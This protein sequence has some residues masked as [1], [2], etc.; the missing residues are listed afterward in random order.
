[1]PSQVRRNCMIYTMCSWKMNTLY[2]NQSYSGIKITVYWRRFQI[3]C[4][5]EGI[6]PYRSVLE[7]LKGKNILN[8]C[9]ELLNQNQVL[10]IKLFGF[11]ALLL[12]RVKCFEDFENIFIFWIWKE[13]KLFEGDIG[14][15]LWLLEGILFSTK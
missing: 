3:F 4:A 5:L 6:L 10:T 1:M 12:L 2:L 11:F 15:N 7:E 8:L 14:E 13:N 9:S